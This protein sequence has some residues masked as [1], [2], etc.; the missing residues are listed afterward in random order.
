MTPCPTTYGR[1][2]KAGD[3]VAM[4]HDLIKRSISVA[5]AQTL[6]AE[7]REKVVVTGVLADVDKPE[8]T[9]EYARVVER[10]RSPAK[11]AG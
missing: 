8:Y 10:L 6:S 4:T 2:N 9:A 7:E 1:L 11:A 3:G 5:K